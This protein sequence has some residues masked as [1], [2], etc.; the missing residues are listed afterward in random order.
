[1]YEASAPR[2]WNKIPNHIKLA[3][4]KYFVRFLNDNN[5]FNIY[6]ASPHCVKTLITPALQMGVYSITSNGSVKKI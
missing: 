6:L 5:F 3:A 4:S 2:L 1:M